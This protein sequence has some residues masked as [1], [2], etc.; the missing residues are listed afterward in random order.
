MCE[1]HVEI[2]FPKSLNKNNDW[3]CDPKGALS[4]HRFQ[5]Y[6][7]ATT[8]SE[9]FHLGGSLR[10]FRNDLVRGKFIFS[11][12]HLHSLQYSR[13][14]N[15]QK[16]VSGDTH[17]PL[18]AKAPGGEND[19][20][21]HHLVVNPL[22]ADSL[23]NNNLSESQL[24]A[25]LG[26]THEC[27]H[28]V[29]HHREAL[30]HYTGK[31]E[32]K[33]FGATTDL[34]EQ[35][36]DYLGL[37][38]AKPYWS[39]EYKDT[40]DEPEIDP[41]PPE[42]WL[43]LYTVCP[44]DIEVDEHK[45]VDLNTVPEEQRPKMLE[46]IYKELHDLCKIGAFELV[47][48]PERKR[49]ITSRMVLKVK[50]R[51]DGEYDK[52]KARLVA[53]GFLAKV[54]IE[55]FSTFS[56]M[57]SLTSVRAVI[58]MA[59]EKGFDIWHCDIP[60]AF[61]QSEIDSDNTF[62]ELP[63]YTGIRHKGKLSRIVKLR[64][65]LYGLKQSPQLWNKAITAFFVDE[66][67]MRRATTETSLYYKK[68]SKGY[69]LVLSEVDDMVITGTPE[70]IEELRLKLKAK[71]DIKQF[72]PL[73]SFLGIN[74]DYDKANGHL[75][76]DVK[77]KIDTLFAERSELNGIGHSTLPMEHT[78][79]DRKGD[80][81]CKFLSYLA[82]P[83]IY[84]SIVGSCIYL[85]VTCRPDISHAVGRCSRGMHSPTKENLIQLKTLLKYLRA[86]SHYKLNYHRSDHPLKSQLQK[87]A[88]KDKELIS[89]LA[90]RKS[91]WLKST[92]TEPFDHLFGTTDADYAS[93]HEESRKS[94]TGYCFFLFHNL[95][96]WKS[97]LQPILA[98]STHE[99][100]LIALN[101][102][103]QEAIWLRNLISEIKSA[104]TGEELRKLPPTKILCDN[105]GAVHTA[106][107]PVSSGRSKHIEI[108]YLK[109]REYQEQLHLKVKHVDGVSNIADMFTKPL[110]KETF[111]NYLRALGM[112]LR[113]PEVPLV[114]TE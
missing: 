19:D 44:D 46:A 105:M 30:L 67:D 51:A 96:C 71:Y 112:E 22:E 55:F 15:W 110:P 86:T 89:L 11:D 94:T 107:N 8:V 45:L 108:R 42:I 50:Y 83:S 75:S 17:Q 9:F 106:T 91:D 32:D 77:S 31:P 69:L 48:I 23:P 47:P 5:V 1:E 16:L 39:E 41:K 43:S 99:A 81:I 65:A 63:K 12:P 101:I 60:S 52:H 6:N 3:A 82:K 80:K 70:L 109:I 18:V 20:A 58:S 2:T 85:A 53:R 103:A 88:L 26:M 87:Y 66:C 34:D 61:I 92:E 4:R 14:A 79:P 33:L 24:A 54:G 10:D 25:N 37:T 27:Y 73:S 100:E 104:V 21:I 59:V 62:I 76:M 7:H 78:V 64:K 95:I 102:A 35:I 40:L 114:I 74:I 13:G 38:I 84:A 36:R 93:K 68:N 111:N 90:L 113:K 72:E 98:T 57:A 49:P 28:T 97:K 56:P 29:K